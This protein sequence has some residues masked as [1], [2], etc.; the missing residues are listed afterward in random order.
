M[1]PIRIKHYKVGRPALGL[2][3]R[4][5]IMAVRE[6]GGFLP[7]AR[8]LGCSDVYIRLKHFIPNGLTLQAVLESEGEALE[9][10]INNV[11]GQHGV[12]MGG[13]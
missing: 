4:Q 2:T 13:G 11:E 1:P 3:T 5:V 6:Q 8:V 7:A 10:L 9:R 12:A